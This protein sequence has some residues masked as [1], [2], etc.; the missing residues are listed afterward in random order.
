MGSRDW[1]WDTDR[2]QPASSSL[3][4]SCHG[5]SLELRSVVELVRNSSDSQTRAGAGGK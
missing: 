5:V 2:P 3:R 4:P 1:T